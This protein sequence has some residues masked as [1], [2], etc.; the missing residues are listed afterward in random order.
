MRKAGHFFGMKSRRRAAER[1]EGWPEG[2]FGGSV[3]IVFLLVLDLGL[4]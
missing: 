4:A 2:K 3:R 1:E